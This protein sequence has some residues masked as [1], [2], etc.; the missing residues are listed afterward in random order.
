MKRAG[1]V[2]PSFC[3]LA[4]SLVS[5]ILN[6]MKKS[7]S[8]KQQPHEMLYGAHPIVEMLKA[9]KRK[10]YSIYTTKPL[11]KAWDRIKP[12]LPA[13]IPNIQYVERTQLDRMA[14]NFDHQSIIALV[15]PFVYAKT[16]FTPDKHPFIL[17]LDAIQ[18]VH[19]VGAIL[20]SAYC[21]GVTGVV[22][23]KT[24]S[25]PLTPAVFKTSAG[26]AEHL[27]IY[28]AASLKQAVSDIKKAGYTICLAVMNGKPM[29]QVSFKAPVCLVIGNEETGIQKDILSMGQQITIPQISPDVSY[30]A[31]VAA[32]ILLFWIKEQ[33]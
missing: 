13:R 15:G 1:I 4:P 2:R 10:L 19:N 24:Q 18:D 30:N 12:F 26:L 22:M 11:P 29:T 28:Q 20:R 33:L 32:G 21:T 7:S 8:P 9:K 6:P 17:L 23:C 25:A 27:Q 14:G 31:S 3:F 16:M 5:F